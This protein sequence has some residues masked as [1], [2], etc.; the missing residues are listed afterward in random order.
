MKKVLKV[1]NTKLIDLNI[2]I[3]FHLE[4]DQEEED[5]RKQEVEAA[6]AIDDGG[7]DDPIEPED[8]TDVNKI[9]CIFLFSNIFSRL[10]I[11]V[12]LLIHTKR[13]I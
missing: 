5:R 10:P 2:E 1:R 13:K 6:R 3:C 11:N 7:L 8:P 9:H 12:N 4:L